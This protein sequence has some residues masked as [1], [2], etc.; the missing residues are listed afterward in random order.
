MDRI[1]TILE[2]QLRMLASDKS[3]SRITSK[4]FPILLLL[5]LLLNHCGPG[6]PLT[7]D[8][9]VYMGRWTN[10]ESFIQIYPE[11]RVDYR[12]VSERG[13]FSVNGAAL[14]I[15]QSRMQLNVLGNEEIWII[16]EAPVK[17]DGY[18]SMTIDNRD[19]SR[20]AE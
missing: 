20:P 8:Q 9:A 19:Y 15:E 14:T 3:G 11:G 7:E 2:S 13:T 1:A 4:S 12:I 16:D 5:I 10:G 18:W 17:R 6:T